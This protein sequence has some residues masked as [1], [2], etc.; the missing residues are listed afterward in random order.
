M[1]IFTRI[2]ITA[3]ALLI[4]DSS[5]AQS[6][7]AVDETDQLKIAAIEALMTAPPDRALPIVKKVING[8]HSDEVKSR[9]L[10][11]LSQI[12]KPESH[13]ILLDAALT[14][15]GNFRLEAI[16]MI[17][18]TGNPETMA[19]LADIHKNGDE[20]VRESVLRAYLIAGDSEAV[21]QVAANAMDDDEFESAV[22]ILGAMGATD[23]LAKLR[24]REGN[25]ESLI[26]AYAIAGDYE[27]LRVL[28]MDT[29]KPDQQMQA[30]HGLGIVGGDESNAT[31]VEIYH[32]TDNSEV[33]DA[34][35]HGMFISNYEQG[36]LE[37]YKS[38][39]DA[40]EKRE[41]LRMLVMI[42]SDAALDIIDAT[43]SGDR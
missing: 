29:S 37:I 10:F 8:N 6:E 36:V 2:L 42:D 26:H 16:R 30:I 15:S 20:N 1:H 33:K 31:L 43:L 18:I 27:G 23:Q 39:N 7:G 41:L 21:Y 38:S 24:G 13:A 19:E 22:H 4:A 14:G 12:D 40:E 9:A 3:I 11:V 5:I 25:S 17:G 34:A 28:A 32:G 35:L